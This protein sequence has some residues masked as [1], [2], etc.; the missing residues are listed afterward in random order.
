VRED[1][2]IAFQYM[3]AKTRYSDLPEHLRRYRADIFD[4]KYKRLDENGL[5]RTITAHIA[6]DGTGTST[7]GTTGPSPSAEAARIQTFP[8]GTVRW[9]A[10]AAFGRSATRSRRSLVEELGKACAP[11]WTPPVL[12]D[13]H[14]LIPATRSRNGSAL[15]QLGASMASSSTRWR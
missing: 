1:D 5:S 7:P 6:K 3:D 11:A 12:P 13:R 9:T 4:D 14:P 2:K 10:V 8:I 15:S